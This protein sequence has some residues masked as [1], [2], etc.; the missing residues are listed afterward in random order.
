MFEKL[1]FGRMA[2]LSFSAQNL[3]VRKPKQE[4]VDAA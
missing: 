4:E 1:P 3:P 2:E